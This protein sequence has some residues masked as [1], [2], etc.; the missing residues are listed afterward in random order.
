MGCALGSPEP[1]EGIRLNPGVPLGEALVPPR[2]SCTPLPRLCMQCSGFRGQ[3]PSMQL[4]ISLEPGLLD[5][6]N[7]NADSGA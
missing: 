1:R 2:C 5:P 6:E 4:G 7:P 3:G